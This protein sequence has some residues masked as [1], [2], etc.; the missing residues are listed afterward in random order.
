MKSAKMPFHKESTMP[1]K[2]NSDKGPDSAS[3][4][5]DI[6]LGLKKRKKYVV[7]LDGV[8]EG[9]ESPESFVIKFSLLAKV[10]VTKIKYH[11]TRLP[12][13]IWTGYGKGKAANLVS[14]ID[15]AGGVAKMVEVDASEEAQEHKSDQKDRHNVKHICSRCGFPLKEGDK[16][17]NFCMTP[18]EVKEREAGSRAEKGK[19]KKQEEVKAAKEVTQTEAKGFSIP[20]VRLLSYLVIVLVAIIISLIIRL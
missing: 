14:L 11:M 3:G 1:D 15:E 16:F 20:P 6:A 7:I 4:V 17:C 2:Y 13:T 8:K 10:P 9:I 19:S 5:A 12:S 18:V